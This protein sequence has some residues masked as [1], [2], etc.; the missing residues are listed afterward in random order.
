MPDLR[1]AIIG[2]G[3][4]GRTFHAPLIAATPGLSVAAVVTADPGRRAQAAAE[5]PGVQVLDGADAL[6]AAGGFDAVVIATPNDAHAPLASAAIDRG[7][8]AVVDKP[9]AVDVAEAQALVDRAQAAGV[10]LTVFQNRRWDA[11]HLTLA[12]LLEGGQLGRVLRYE[13]RFER[14]RPTGTPDAW[15]ERVPPGQGGGLL[16]DLGSHLVD[17]AL[18]L[19]GPVT[20]VYA[21]IASRRG[22]VAD[23]DDFLALTHASGPISHLWL[24]ALAA[25]SGPRLRVLGTEAAFVAPGLDSQEDELRAGRRPDTDPDWGVQPEFRRGRL[26]AGERS[27][28]LAGEPGDWPRFYA[29]LRDALRDGGPPPVD[30]RDAVRTLTVLERARASAARRQVVRVG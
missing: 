17:Q 10:L 8:A 13:S 16:L 12:R 30:P 11:D 23:D 28:P 26:I 18:T 9:L 1:V 29:L 7:V 3:L 22:G 15:R 19:F 14:W 6:W 20:E 5:H 27:V 21:E 25:A 24:S 2:Y 4:A